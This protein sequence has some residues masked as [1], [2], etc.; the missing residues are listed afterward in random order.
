MPSPVPVRPLKPPCPCSSG[1]FP[2]AFLTRLPPESQRSIQPCPP[3]RTCSKGNLVTREA[4]PPD[5]ED[6]AGTLVVEEPRFA[7]VPEWV[8]DAAVSDGAF[9][10]YSLLLRYGE[11]LRL[12][13]AVPANPGPAP[14]PASRLSAPLRRY[15]ERLR[16]PDAVP[17]NPGPAPSPLGRRRRPSDAPA[18]RSR[19]RPRRA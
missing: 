10:L 5:T 11:R 1:A 3:H 2:D 17:A 8:I 16:L 13:D 12:P 19:H 9:R 4:P 18:H 15:G 7:I 6:S 14:S